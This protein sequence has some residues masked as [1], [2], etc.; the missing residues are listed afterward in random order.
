MFCAVIF[1]KKKLNKKRNIKITKTKKIA[2][3]FKGLQIKKN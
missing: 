2:V 1:R 3:S